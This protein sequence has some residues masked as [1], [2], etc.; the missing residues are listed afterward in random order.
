MFDLRI[1]IRR[2]RE[3]VAKSSS[4]IEIEKMIRVVRLSHCNL[5]LRDVLT[6]ELCRTNSEDVGAIDREARRELGAIGINIAI[7]GVDAAV[8][9]SRIVSVCHTRVAGSKDDGYSL[10]TKFHPFMALSFLVKAR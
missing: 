10:E 1:L 5:A 3:D 9:V 7:L 2:S 8:V 4:R 6:L